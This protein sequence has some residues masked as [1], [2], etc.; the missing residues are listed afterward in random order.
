MMENN[1][2][3][4]PANGAKLEL[5]A[6]IT[7]PDGRVV[8]KKVEAVGGI[9]APEEFDTSDRDGFLATYDRFERSVIDARDLCIARKTCFDLESE[10]EYGHFLFVFL[11]NKGK[12]GSKNGIHFIKFHMIFYGYARHRKK[13]C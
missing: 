5:V 11:R 2:E 12:L 13:T 7:L 4:A 1:K 8:E 3:Q 6:R 9:P 10:A